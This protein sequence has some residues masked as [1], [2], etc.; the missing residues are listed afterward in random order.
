MSETLNIYPASTKIYT[1]EGMFF[2]VPDAKEEVPENHGL[3]QFYEDVHEIRER[4]KHEIYIVSGRKGC[5]KTA[6]FRY[7][8]NLS[9]K[10]Y[11]IHCKSFL[12]KDY[13]LEKLVQKI[14]P[15]LVNNYK[16][17]YEWIILVN[18][19]EMILEVNK[20]AIA[21]AIVDLA[22]FWKLNSGHLSI[23]SLALASSSSEGGKDIQLGIWDSI[24]VG[25]R[26]AF[27][28][29]YRKPEFY[30]LLKDLRAKV[31][32]ALNYQLHENHEFF[33]F[34]DDLDENFDITSEEQCKQLISLI[35]EAR[36]FNKNYLSGST[37]K[38]V[39]LIREDH[40]DRLSGHTNSFTKAKEGGRYVLNWYNPNADNSNEAKLMLRKFVN[41]RLHANFT[42]LNISMSHPED[43]WLDFI[44]T[45]PNISFNYSSVF[46]FILSYTQ[47][48]PRDFVYLFNNISEKNFKLP[49]DAEA[50]IKLLVDYVRV[51]YNELE[52]ELVNSLPKKG[53]R[54]KFKKSFAHLMELDTYSHIQ[55]KNRI[56]NQG[57]ENSEL[58]IELMVTYNIIIPFDKANKEYPHFLYPNL[59]VDKK[60]HRFKLAKWIKAYY[61][62]SYITDPNKATICFG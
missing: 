21:D 38:V 22:K 36:D 44:D 17:L 8:E 24:T 45:K 18:F 42:K 62:E 53:I 14:D 34:F 57:L 19:T 32:K 26:K 48:R 49:L 55:V 60:K 10:R 28:K 20:G 9:E 46:R 27:S 6:F 52:D 50:V 2:G 61:D 58:Y 31:T 47:C 33:L 5:G 51:A 4:L 59:K 56:E 30:E 39:I 37:G 3:T 25:L 54:D 7:I 23:T 16:L 29:V 11:E 43:P 35:E 13:E 41:K 1:T 15:Q 12:P 40:V